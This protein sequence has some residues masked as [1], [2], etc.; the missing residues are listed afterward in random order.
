M[1]DNRIQT[2]SSMKRVLL[3]I[4]FSVFGTAVMIHLN[5]Y[6]NLTRFMRAYSFPGSE[7]FFVF[8]PAFFAMGLALYA[9]KQ[10]EELQAEIKKRRATEEALLKS[11]QKFRDLS[12]TDELTGLHNVRYFFD[13]LDVEIERAKRY[14]TPLSLIFVDIDDFKNY[15]DKYGHLEGDQV[16]RKIAQAIQSCMRGSDSGYRYG[17]DE[18]VVVLPE[19]REAAATVVAERI[20]KLTNDLEFFPD[21]RKVVSMTV[22]VGVTEY[23]SSEDKDT[24]VKRADMNMYVHKNRGKGAT[25]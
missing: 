6:E 3:V 10:I 4:F 2:V 24:F 13:R 22:S 17:G 19:T 23:V 15:N 11:E 25:S 7:E 20:M 8:T 12:I 5:A 16:L 1:S 18:F 9:A 21:S 14:S